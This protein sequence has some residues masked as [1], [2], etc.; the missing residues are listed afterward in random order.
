MQ[1][2]Q[3]NKDRGWLIKVSETSFSLFFFEMESRSFAQAGV[4]CCDLGSLQ[5]LPPGFMPFSCLSLLSCWD[6]RHLPACPAKFFLYFLVETGFHCVRQDGLDLLTSWSALRQCLALLP[7]LECSGA[8][9]AHCKLRLPGSRHSPASASRVAG[10]T[11]TRHL[12]RL[13]CFL[14]FSVETGF[15]HVSRDGLDQDKYF[16]LFWCIF[17]SHI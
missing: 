16:H 8:I 6:Y 13:V 14:D 10:T 5:A 17:I 12:A 4:Q 7:R 3:N 1:E 2:L 15:H 11:G 9:S